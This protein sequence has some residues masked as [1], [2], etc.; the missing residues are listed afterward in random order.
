MNGGAAQDNAGAAIKKV[1]EDRH[2][3][4]E[5]EGAHMVCCVFRM[6]F[7]P[8]CRR[9]KVKEN[10]SSEILVQMRALQMSGEFKKKQKRRAKFAPDRQ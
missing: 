6:T 7:I 9:L 3:E 1:N 10:L 5:R 8:Q 2:G 4:G